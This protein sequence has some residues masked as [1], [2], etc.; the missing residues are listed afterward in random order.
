MYYEIVG[1]Y[2]NLVSLYRSLHSFTVLILVHSISTMFLKFFQPSVALYLAAVPLGTYN[3]A[4]E[5]V[6]LENVFSFIANGFVIF[7][8]IFFIL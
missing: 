6:I 4:L 7:E 3:V 1:Y 2:Y 8:V 5:Y